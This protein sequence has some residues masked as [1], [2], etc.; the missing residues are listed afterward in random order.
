VTVIAARF[1]G[2]GS[3]PIAPVNNRISSRFEQ[4]E[5]SPFDK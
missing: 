3:H 1:D 2:T 4:S 5:M